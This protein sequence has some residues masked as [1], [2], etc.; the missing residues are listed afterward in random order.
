VNAVLTATTRGDAG[1]M[2]QLRAAFLELLLADPRVV[3][4]FDRWGRRSGLDRAAAAL[5]RSAAARR[6]AAT[7]RLFAILPVRNCSTLEPSPTAFVR[8]TLASRAASTGSRR[9]SSTGSTGAC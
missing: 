9:S 6:D 1:R 7:S 3:Q 4:L 2:V 5:A 8:D